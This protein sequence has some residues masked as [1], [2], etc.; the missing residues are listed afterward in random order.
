MSEEKTLRGIILKGV[1]GFYYVE[2]GDKIYECKARGAFRKRGITPLAGDR[3]R[4]TVREDSYCTI[5][6]IEPRKN[7][8]VRPAVANIDTLFIVAASV[9]PSPSYTVIDRMTAMAE[10]NDI[11]PIIVVTKL[12]LSGA[13][14]L[15]AVYR[16]A[17][18]E[19]VE[20][21]YRVGAGIDRIRDLMR[22]K[23]SAFA[24]NSGVGKSTLLNAIEP[25][26]LLETGDISEKLGRGRH[27]TRSVELFS[28]SFGG[29]I[30][31]TPG[32][33]SFDGELVMNIEKE[34][35]QYCFKE[36]ERYI[37]D[38]RFTG[39]A[40]IREKGC[41]VLEAVRQ[42]EIASSRHNSYCLM[43]EEAKNIKPWEQRPS[44]NGN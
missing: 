29:R 39:C 1:G 34:Q 32:F 41:A 31:D 26:L 5:D 12:D 9:K 2:C 36:F 3:C 28:L 40:H 43:Y 20:I 15:C 11:Q 23:I 22:D 6:E 27:T 19:V 7:C 33:A 4:V 14:E 30:A 17:G 10:K 18:F 24:G 16:L 13:D 44:N 42:G 21:D 35:L 25:K 38:C 37:P 8:L